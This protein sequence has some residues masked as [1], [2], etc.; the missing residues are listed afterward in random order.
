[1]NS[2]LISLVLL[3][4][5]ADF[6]SFSFCREGLETIGSVQCVELDPS[7]EGTFK[8]TSPDADTIDVAVQ[9]SAAATGRFV[10]LL[11][12]TDYLVDGDQYESGRQVANLGI[13]TLVAEGSW[14]RREAVFNFSTRSEVRDLASF[15]DRLIVQEM[16]LLDLEAAV[17]FD[18]LGIPRHLENVEKQL[19]A[20]RFA[21]AR[22]WIPVLERIE[23]DRRILNFARSTAAR[24]KAEIEENY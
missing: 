16:L 3:F 4:T 11:A 9:L 13:K 17:F 19:R 21:D 7:G 6:T 5:Q 1:M 8:I 22:R 14:G 20:D 12:E 10:R 15:V 23:A 24:L 2:F 18:R